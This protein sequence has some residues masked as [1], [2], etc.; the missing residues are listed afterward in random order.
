MTTVVPGQC[1]EAAFQV[2]QTADGEEKVQYVPGKG[3]TVSTVAVGG[4][5]TPVVVATA[6]GSRI[7]QELESSERTYVVSVA[8]GE[9]SARVAALPES[10]RAAT[11]TNLPREGDVVLAKVTRVTAKQ[12][13]CEVVTVEGRGVVADAGAGSTGAAAHLS[14]PM[15]GGLQLLSSYGAVALFQSTMAGAMAVDTG[16]TFRGLVRA[17]DVRQTDRDRVKMAECF[18]A[19]DIVRAQVLSL[20]DGANYYLTTAR[21]DLGVVLA[22]SAGEQ[23]VAVD[24]ETMLCESTGATEKRK[25]AKLFVD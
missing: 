25:C 1:L 8:R 17:Q 7:V 19:G 10:V 18:R 15:G 2:R 16:E 21:N 12:A 20:G 13:H 22:R 5:P 23:M 24:W 14:V 3:A 11:A 9:Y 6:L 4:V